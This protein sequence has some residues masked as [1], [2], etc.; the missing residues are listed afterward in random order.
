MKKILLTSGIAV[1]LLL[2]ASPAYAT[3]VE[4]FASSTWMAPA[5]V[6]S[7]AVRAYAGGGSGGAGLSSNGG[8][9]GGGGAFAS[10]TIS[11]VPGNTYIVSVGD[12]TFG[13]SGN[14]NIG[15]P[16][17]FESTATIYAAPGL[18]GLQNGSPTAT[19]GGS[20]ASSTGALVFAGG[21]SGTIN[22]GTT[23]GGGGGGAG[24]LGAGGNG[25]GLTGGIAGAG[26][27]SGTGGQGTL[28]GAGGN[29]NPTG[30]GGG[31]S[32]NFAGN[33]GTG[34]RGEVDLFFS[35]STPSSTLV[36]TWFIQGSSCVIQGASLTI[37]G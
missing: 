33:G 16:S 2:F 3:E 29:G 14:G 35:T 28:S 20:V 34:A 5:T 7:V 17:W 30:G 37:T 22:N 24:S 1:A 13:T 25:S 23:P 36:S 15:N 32:T 8:G 12:Q 31:G 26:A 10:D 21:N 18:G 11:V 9:G 4:F 6:T 19:P 27:N